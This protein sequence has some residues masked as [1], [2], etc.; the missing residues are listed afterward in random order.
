MTDKKK[1]RLFG[2]VIRNITI[3]AVGLGFDSQAVRIKAVASLLRCVSE[4]VLPRR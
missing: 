4:A 2:V 3:G 1:R